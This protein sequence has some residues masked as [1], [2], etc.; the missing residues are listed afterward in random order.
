MI[1][2]KPNSSKQNETISDFM[3][4]MKRTVRQ[5]NYTFKFK[6]TEKKIQKKNK[7]K[8]NILVFY[9]IKQTEIK[10]IEIIYIVEWH[11][12]KQTNKIIIKKTE[13]NI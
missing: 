8:S 1:H 4:E 10:L 5:T 13:R 9:A 3:Q 7:S 6:W 2:P 12:H 11:T